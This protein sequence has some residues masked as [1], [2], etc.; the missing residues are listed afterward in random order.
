MYLQ[1]HVN[2]ITV[3]SCPP[4]PPSFT[5]H[6]HR[7][8]PSQC[9]I[10]CAAS[11]LHRR[12]AAGAGAPGWEW[13]ALNGKYLS[14]SRLHDCGFCDAPRRLFEESETPPLPPPAPPAGPEEPLA[15]GRMMKRCHFP[16]SLRR[17]DGS[18]TPADQNIYIAPDWN[19]FLFKSLF[20]W[21]KTFFCFSVN[22][23]GDTCCVSIEMQ[24]LK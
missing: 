6:L 23:F 8:Q 2:V 10:W 22:E 13:N 21:Q 15:K 14:S 1:P 9:D 11:P 7:A 18:F 5:L 4:P 16:P 12:P 24:E 17:N 20:K 19:T 3:S